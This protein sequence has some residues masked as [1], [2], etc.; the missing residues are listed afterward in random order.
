M[1][2][3]RR[4]KNI[5]CFSVDSRPFFSNPRHYFAARRGVN[6][7][8]HELNFMARGGGVSRDFFISGQAKAGNKRWTLCRAKALSALDARCNSAW[9][10]SW[11][12][13]GE[14]DILRLWR[15][16]LAG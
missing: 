5:V 15:C 3:L 12:R 9:L 16:D 14:Y 11:R 10:K 1:T 2:D 6:V 4:F 13:K 7:I 8:G